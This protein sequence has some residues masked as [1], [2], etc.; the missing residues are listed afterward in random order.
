MSFLV[1]WLYDVLGVAGRFWQKDAKILFL[2]LDNSGKT[3]L[4]HMLKLQR[5]VQHAPTQ[6]P[7]SEELSIGRSIFKAFDLGGHQMARRVWKDYYAAKVDAVVYMV[8]AAD[9]ARFARV[10]GGARRAHW[11]TTRWPGRRSRAREQDDL[12]PWAA[13]EHELAYHSALL[14][15]PPARVGLDSLMA[16]CVRPVGCSCAASCVRWVWE[17]G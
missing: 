12:A 1:D 17:K 7:T 11:P 3:T 9:G 6:Q 8:D 13:P 15:T 2:G 14:D 4:L 5:L 16:R 10:E